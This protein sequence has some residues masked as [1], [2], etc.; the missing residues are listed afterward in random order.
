M[1]M[2]T[3]MMLAKV[4]ILTDLMIPTDVVKIQT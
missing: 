3:I 1:G 2:G 4:V